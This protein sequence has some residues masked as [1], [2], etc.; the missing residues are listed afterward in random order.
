MNPSPHR[1]IAP[2]VKVIVSN[3]GCGRLAMENH[4]R[5]FWQSRHNLDRPPP[6]TDLPALADQL[7]TTYPATHQEPTP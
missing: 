5:A 2:N 3:T 6:L 1:Y 7:R 4:V